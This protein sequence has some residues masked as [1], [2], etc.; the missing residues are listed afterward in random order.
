VISTGTGSGKT[1]A[2]LYP[3]I[4]R[5]LEMREQQAPAGVVAVLVYPM[6]ALA[7]DQ[8][9]RLRGLLHDLPAAAA[10]GE[11]ARQGLQ[12]LS[13]YCR[14]KIEQSY[15]D[16][17]KNAL[18]LLLR[19]VFPLGENWPAALPVPTSEEVFAFAESEY[20]PAKLSRTHAVVYRATHGKA[21]T[22]GDVPLLDLLVDPLFGWQELFATR[23]EA[24]DVPSGHHTLLG[25]EQIAIVGRHLRASFEDLQNHGAAE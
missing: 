5:C 20:T 12:R 6:N 11:A 22:V 21:G 1:E 7:E 9:E 8:L 10:N 14:R 17:R 13:A 3:I 23:V 25:A 15:N 19:H 18:C 24:I 2:F 4:S 16:A